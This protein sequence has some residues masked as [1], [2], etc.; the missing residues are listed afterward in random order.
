MEAEAFFPE[1]KENEDERIRKDMIIW[2]KGFIGEASG[3]GYTENE[4]KERIAWLEK[5]GEHKDEENTDFTIYYPLKNGK[6]KY[7]SIPYSFYGTLTSFSES[8]DLINFLRNCFYSEEECEEWIKHQCETISWKPTKEQYEALN[9]AYN[10]C[11][12][13]EKGNYYKGVLETL[14]EDLHNLEKQ[15]SQVLANSAKICK[16]EPKFKVGDFIVN[17]YCVG[18]IV[19]ITNDAYLLD[20]KQGIPFS[21]HSTRLWDITKDAIDGDVLQL[22][23]VTAI[24][25][26]YIG[27][28]HCICY[29][30]FCKDGGFEIPIANGEDNNYGCHFVALATKEQRD[31]LFEKMKEAGYE[32]D[33][34]KKELK[35]IVQKS[36]E[37]FKGN[38]GK[39]SST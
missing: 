13:T 5:Q 26:K 18:R 7:E 22:G 31:I 21:C 39:T 3:V 38:N 27:N 23:E 2:L 19:D 33:D 8:I 17:D 24:F 12:D 37:E 34:E 6:G 35:K 9:Y 16:I 25:N 30:S 10:S 14:I 29:C 20:T 32:W 36:V 11:S 1:L 4:I 15:G 28:E